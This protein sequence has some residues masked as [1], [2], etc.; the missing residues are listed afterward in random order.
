MDSLRYWVRDM[1]VDGFRFDL[2]P[3]LARSGDGAVEMHG[4]FLAALGQDPVLR[5]VKLVAEPWDVGAG[6]YQVGRFP[7]PWSEWNDRYRNCVRDFWRGHCD[8]VQELASRLTGSS[9]LYRSPTASVN[10][11]TAHD[12][13]TLRDLVSYDG[14][15]NEANG[16]DN[17]DGEGHNRSWNCGIEGPGPDDVEV[18][19]RRQSRNFLTTLLLSAGVPMLLA[20]DELRRT[21][22]GNNNAYC[23]DELS[24][25]HWTNSAAGWDLLAW[26]AAL[27]RVRKTAPGLRSEAFL[28]GHELPGQDGV[29][30]LA[31]FGADGIEMSEPQW[32]E[33]SRQ[34]LGRYV[35]GRDAPQRPGSLLLWLHAGGSDTTVTLPGRAWG[36]SWDVLLDTA[37]ERPEPGPQ[38][39]QPGTVLPVIT[40]SAV[41]LRCDHH[42]SAGRS[43]EAS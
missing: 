14:K 10:F 6:G 32:Q 33:R 41:L 35:D 17:R 7:P 13:F 43:G 36:H 29:R 30:D 26:T 8:G 18:L 5:R 37:L 4:A 3:A 19:R 34:T 23:Q 2:A 22:R 40:R 9:D 39:L 42:Y 25:L 1:H 21:Q 24:Y 12:G 20:G 27:L 38:G 16:E 11:V 28:G 31:W 15:H